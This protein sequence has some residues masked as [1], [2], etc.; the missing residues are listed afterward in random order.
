MAWDASE[1]LENSIY[2]LFSFYKTVAAGAA[3]SESISIGKKWKIH[4]IRIHFSVAFASVE[5]F[6]AYI[7]ATKG[8]AH[9]LT[10][11]SYACNGST[12]II[13]YYS[14][15]RIFLSD[16]ELVL[17]FS[18]SGSNVVGINVQGWAVQG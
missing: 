4:E 16:D 8:S 15:P 1:Y 5:D 14:S 10:L 7:S 9:N 3:L 6:V 12:D 17:T 2:Q 11:L 13:L 18:N